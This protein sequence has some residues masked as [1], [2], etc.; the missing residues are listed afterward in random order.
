MNNKRNTPN[1]K[2]EAFW[3]FFFGSIWFNTFLVCTVVLLQSY[4]WFYIP[5]Y[6]I[7]AISLASSLHLITNGVKTLIKDSDNQ[8][9]L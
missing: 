5:A 1:K 6:F 9:D 2:V 7:G 3:N 4:N 8:S